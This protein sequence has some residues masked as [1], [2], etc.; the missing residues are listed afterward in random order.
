M[1]RANRSAKIW[2]QF[3]KLSAPRLKMYL[4]KN[5]AKV[6]QSEKK[7]FLWVISELPD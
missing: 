4:L 2:M 7:T 3:L 6:Q 1:E 5:K